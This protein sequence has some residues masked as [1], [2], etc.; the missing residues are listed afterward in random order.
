MLD[1]GS[2]LLQCQAM[3]ERCENITAEEYEKLPLQEIL[4]NWRIIPTHF[5]ESHCQYMAHADAKAFRYYIPAM[6][7]SSLSGSEEVRSEILFYLR[8]SKEH[9]GYSMSRYSLLDDKQRSAIA[10]YLHWLPQIVKS[11]EML[12]KQCERALQNY[13]HQFL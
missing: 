4:D 5:L 10:Q 2:S 12:H 11:D 6:M 9:W 3:D 1:G 8:P 13:W 7:R